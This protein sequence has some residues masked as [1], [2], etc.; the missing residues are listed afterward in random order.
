M[1]V[2]PHATKGLAVSTSL[3]GWMTGCVCVCVCESPCYQEAGGQCITSGVDDWMCVCV[4]TA[5][6]P[7]YQGAGISAQLVVWMTG[8]VCVCVDMGQSLCHQGAQS[9]CIA[10]AMDDLM[11]VCVWVGGWGGR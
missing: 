3:V 9:H 7:C 11:D 2:S 5:Q 6:S 1:W 10:G 8:C 4:D